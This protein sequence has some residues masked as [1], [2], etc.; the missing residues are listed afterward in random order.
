MADDVVR[1]SVVSH[2]VELVHV[3]V[4]A[5]VMS[6]ITDLAFSGLEEFLKI[7][8]GSVKIAVFKQF[9]S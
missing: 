3:V 4:M 7:F 2:E 1:G 9:P 5:A 6:C 8:C